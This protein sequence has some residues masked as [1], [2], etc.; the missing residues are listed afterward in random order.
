MSIVNVAERICRRPRT[1]INWTLILIV[2]LWLVLTGVLIIAYQ[3]MP[4]DWKQG[5]VSCLYHD[6]SGASQF[7]C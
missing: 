7:R 4:E 6:A 2:V 3:A 1:A 5:R